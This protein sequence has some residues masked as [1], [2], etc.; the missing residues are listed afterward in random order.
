MAEKRRNPEAVKVEAVLWL[1]LSARTPAEYERNRKRALQV[2]H[3][4]AD[5]VERL[6]P[7]GEREW[8]PRRMRREGPVWRGFRM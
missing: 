3:M 2:A 7:R 6:R 4:T 8:K 5:E 1:L